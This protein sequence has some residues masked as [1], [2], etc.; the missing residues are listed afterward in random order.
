MTFP[1][2]LGS[3]PETLSQALEKITR[4]AGQVKAAAQQIRAASLTGPTGVNNVITYLGDLADFR[5]TLARLSATTGLAAFAQAQYS[6]ASLDIAADYTTMLA[7][8]DA[9][10][11][12]IA[13]NFPKA[14]SGEL[15]EKKFDAN[16]RVVLNTFT[17]A[18]LAGFRTQLDALIATID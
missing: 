18:A 8:I 4:T 16:G 7:A 2:S 10:R 15:L 1:S 17:T 3:K 14:A 12:W 5:D 13:T 6:S 11:T 9:V